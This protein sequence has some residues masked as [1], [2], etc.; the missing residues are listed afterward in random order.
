[1]AT[2]NTSACLLPRAPAAASTRAVA[3]SPTTARRP[4][5]LQVPQHGWGPRHLLVRDAEG[6]LQG[7]CPLYL[8]GHSYGEYVF[9]QSWANYCHM[10]G[11]D[12]YPKLQ[13]CVPFTPVTGPRLMARPGE[14]GCRRR[15]LCPRRVEDLAAAM[16]H[17]PPA[18]PLPACATPPAAPHAGPSPPPP[19][20]QARRSRPSARRWRRR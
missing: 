19:R 2:H 15:E 1:V 20:P 8:K 18:A 3:A 16:A 11:K 7:C 17:A 12:Y 4:R 6:A 14:L 10:L 13:S 5:L 9:D